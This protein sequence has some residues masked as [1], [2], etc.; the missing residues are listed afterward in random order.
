MAQGALLRL[1]AGGRLDAKKGSPQ[2]LAKAS[3]RRQ[4][5]IKENR[6]QSQNPLPLVNQTPK[7]CATQIRLST[8]KALPPPGNL[9]FRRL[10]GAIDHDHVGRRSL[11]FKL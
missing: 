8:L 9:F 6:K 1:D 7:G 2:Y 10:L 3:L 11:Y 5:S 4:G